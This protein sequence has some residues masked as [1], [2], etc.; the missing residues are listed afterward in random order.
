MEARRLENWEHIKGEIRRLGLDGRDAEADQRREDEPAKP[1][2][3]VS[4]AGDGDRT[5]DQRLGKP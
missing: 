3:H 4:G 5:R 1:C 2:R